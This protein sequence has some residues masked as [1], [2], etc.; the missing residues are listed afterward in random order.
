MTLCAIHALGGEME[1]NSSDDDGRRQQHHRQAERSQNAE[2]KCFLSTSRRQT[3]PVPK[4][5][6]TT[7]V[8]NERNN[9]ARATTPKAVGSSR[10]A[11]TM[12]TANGKSCC[13]QPSASAHNTAAVGPGRLD[14]G[15]DTTGPSMLTEPALS[16][17][18]P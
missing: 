1:G 3:M 5:L 4:P 13:P 15:G 9:P 17:S 2:A 7:I 18:P 10:R 12:R 8:Q 11:R 6:S 16:A 14:A